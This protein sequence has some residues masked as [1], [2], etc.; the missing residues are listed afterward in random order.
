[1]TADPQRRRRRTWLALGVAVALVAGAIVLTLIG[2]STLRY[3]QEGEAVGIDDRPVVT[4]PSTSNALLAVR[5]ADGR[6]ASLAVL[7]LLPAGRGG[8][9]VTVPVDADANAGLTV[10]RVS[11]EE[12]FETVRADGT[13]GL[14]E[15]V[16]S[17]ESMLSIT[18]ERALVVDE[19]QLESLIEPVAPIEVTL[20]FDVERDGSVVVAAGERELTAGQTASVL[21]AEGEDARGVHDLGVATWSAL[22]AEAPVPV[23]ETIPTDES[24][25]ALAPA[26]VE[27]LITRLWQGTAQVRDL[28]VM[29]DDEDGD[30]GGDD[31]EA[32]DEGEAETETEDD[33]AV[34]EESTPGSAEGTEQTDVIV[35]DRR[36]SLLVFSQISP[37]LVSTPNPALTF[38]LEIGFT[39]DEVLGSPSGFTSTSDLAR[40]LIGQLLFV[41]G[42]V[43]SVDTTASPEG[44]PEITRIQV[45][46]EQFLDDMTEFA[47]LLFGESEVV[48]AD[49]V[50]EGIDVV[51]EVG[52]A[53]LD[54][55]DT[56]PE[57]VVVDEDAPDPEE[58][59]AVTTDAGEAGPDGDG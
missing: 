17:V 12:E 43:V 35:V 55:E 33:A 41:Q 9:I 21:T 51:I 38:R 46:D 57:S 40:A 50:I 48:L 30:D 23:T 58:D 14:D 25:T 5:G 26:S 34:T 52:T 22:A 6:L 16:A 45:A 8:T 54:L 59:P 13:T 29:P 1:M 44:A 10:E 47:S 15:F 19:A 32:G 37:K 4:L 49:T 3:S 27:E 56:A 7:T 24:G 31:A 18:I 28:L 2:V 36:D 42:N 11:L 53:F 39:E 20:P